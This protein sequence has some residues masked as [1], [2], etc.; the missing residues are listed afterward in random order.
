MESVP[1][2]VTYVAKELHMPVEGLMQRS[3]RAF[4]LQEMR[5]AQLDIG[6]FQDR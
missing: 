5:A 6:D 2:T 1:E 3:V 4:L